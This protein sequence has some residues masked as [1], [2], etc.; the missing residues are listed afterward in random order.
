MAATSMSED[1]VVRIADAVRRGDPQTIVEALGV[2]TG[3]APAEPL[4]PFAVARAALSALGDLI[5][6][7]TVDAGHWSYAIALMAAGMAPARR[8]QCHRELHAIARKM[9]AEHIEWLTSSASPQA[10]VGANILAGLCS[11]VIDASICTSQDTAGEE[12]P[13]WPEPV[14]DVP[15]GTRSTEQRVA[16]LWVSML[17]QSIDKQ[18]EIAERIREI[19]QAT[20]RELVRTAVGGPSLDQRLSGLIGLGELRDEPAD[21]LVAALGDPMPDVRIAALSAIGRRGDAGLAD[22]VAARISDP[23]PDVR[24]LAIDVVARNRQ[25]RALPDLLNAADDPVEGVRRAARDAI[26]S[27]ASHDVLEQIVRALRS[28]ATEEVARDVLVELGDAATDAVIAAIED[29]APRTRERIA[30]VLRATG[31]ARRVLELLH[32]LDPVQRRLAAGAVV[33]M[34]GRDA[35]QTLLGLL[36]DPDHD[37]RARAASLLGEIADQSVTEPLGLA[38]MR[39]PHRDVCA[40]MDAALRKLATVTEGVEEE[41]RDEER[42][43]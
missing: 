13:P 3:T 1:H 22:A 6:E 11:E 15:L 23:R 2:S 41:A 24:E 8:T 26:C 18:R 33:V 39:E 10:R 36:E 7:S 29:A 38:R 5:G 17:G 34:G 4:D 21:P 19:D 35:A 32:G 28:P 31:A 20:L 37:V 43:R 14:A 27:M 25:V 42:K 16:V 12:P 40:A 30:E 9:P